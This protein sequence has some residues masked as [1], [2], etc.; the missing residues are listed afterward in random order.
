MIELTARIARRVRLGQP[1]A[2]FG[3]PPLGPCRVQAHEGVVSITWAQGDACE[4]LILSSEEFE[5]HL[6]AGS[7]VIVPKQRS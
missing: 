6:L 1:D 7:I 5:D 2:R 3:G 4:S